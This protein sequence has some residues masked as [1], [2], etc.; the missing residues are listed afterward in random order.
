MTPDRRASLGRTRS[1]RATNRRRPNV[2]R[3]PGLLAGSNGC[4]FEQDFGAPERHEAPAQRRSPDR[5]GLSG[6]TG[7]LSLAPASSQAETQR[8]P[9]APTSGDPFHDRDGCPS[10]QGC[11][12]PAGSAS[13][14]GPG[15]CP[16]EQGCDPGWPG[17][18]RGERGAGAGSHG[19]DRALGA[20]GILGGER[21]GRSPPIWPRSTHGKRLSS[22]RVRRAALARGPAAVQAAGLSLTPRHRRSPARR[23]AGVVSRSP[24]LRTRGRD[25]RPGGHPRDRRTGAGRPSPTCSSGPGPRQPCPLRCRPRRSEP[26]RGAAAAGQR[27]PA[28]RGNRSRA[29]SEH[30][31]SLESPSSRSP[32]ARGPSANRGRVDFTD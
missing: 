23:R 30:P 2:C 14:R 10:E 4:P 16:F 8:S 11:D 27:L 32:R 21:R 19:S 26:S 29:R 17:G 15:G 5:L 7:P 6:A 18:W 9:G 22:A 20:R 31:T 28:G 1:S 25:G 13:S 12:R 3:S 24:V